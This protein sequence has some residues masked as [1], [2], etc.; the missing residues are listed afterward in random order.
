MGQ[1]L[2]MGSCPIC[3]EPTV[4]SL[5][6]CEPCQQKLKKIS[7]P[8]CPLCGRPFEEKEMISHLCGICLKDKP[9]FDW[10]RSLYF[11]E[12]PLISLVHGLK[13]KAYLFLIPFFV[14][15]LLR[16]HFSYFENADFLIP[17]P[18]SSNR[19]SKRTYNQSLELTK[20][21]SKKTGKPYLRQAL[22]K[23]KETSNQADL[24]L[25]ERQKNLQGAFKWS[26]TGPSLEGKKIILVD[27]VF[28]TGNTLNACA[29]VL[30]KA[31]AK[32]VGCFTLALTPKKNC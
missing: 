3:F 30:K 9:A 25:P 18:L 16:H 31:G 2:A 10:H 6:V 23:V 28:T 27:D 19:L 13:F 7:E 1:H 14:D 5:I 8:F 11:Y 26:E 32:E 24:S 15:H 4:S 20:G 17:A 12:A 22:I 29:E 21:L